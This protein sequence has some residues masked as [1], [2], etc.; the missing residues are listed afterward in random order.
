MIPFLECPSANVDILKTIAIK[1]LFVFTPHGILAVHVFYHHSLLAYF[2]H[3]HT[4]PHSVPSDA[5][6]LSMSDINS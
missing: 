5:P 2:T 4:H 6:T 1:N 3:T